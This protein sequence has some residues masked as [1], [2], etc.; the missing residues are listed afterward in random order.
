MNR[1]VVVRIC[2]Q[3][4]S[5]QPLDGDDFPFTNRFGGGEQSTVAA[6]VRAR[7]FRVFTN[8]ATFPQF[9]M[10]AAY[11]A[12]I[13]LGVEAAVVRVVVFGLALRAHRERFHRSVRAVVRQGFDDAE[14]RAT[15]GAVGE[16][17]TVAAVFWIED[18]AQAIR[19]GGDVRQHQRG[20]VAAGFAG[21][22]FKCRA[23]GGVEPQGFE[24]LDETARRFFGF[25]PEQEFFQFRAQAFGFNK[26]ALRR[27]VD[28]A[29]QSE[30][31]GKAEDE[32]TE[33]DA[34]HRATNGE[35]QARA[36]A[37]WSGLVHEGILS[38]PAPN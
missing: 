3:M 2:H 13:R 20:F 9:E 4:K 31:G 28:P 27:I 8:A 22:D 15:V 7:T 6:L 25:E 36:S 14:A 16:R 38:E 1:F 17:I 23:A 26:D 35:F 37:G 34:L 10:R 21:A 11:R 24:A 29:G 19:A 30:S 33:A 32:R 12:R 18:F 5:A